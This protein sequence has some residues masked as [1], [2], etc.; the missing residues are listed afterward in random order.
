MPAVL[1]EPAHGARFFNIQRTVSCTPLLSLCCI[2]SA[3]VSLMVARGLQGLCNSPT[4][5]FSLIWG[6]V[7]GMLTARVARGVCWSRVQPPS[8]TG[9]GPSCRGSL[10]V[11][12]WWTRLWCFHI[13]AGG[14]CVSGILGIHTRAVLRMALV[15][16]V[17]RSR[18]CTAAKAAG[19]PVPSRAPTHTGE[20]SA[21]LVREAAGS[22]P[23]PFL[24]LLC[25]YSDLP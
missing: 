24:S 11:P 16:R 2:F 9:A 1:Q 4:W 23:A 13:R 6:P 12:M 8:L 17:G 14:E 25:L 3:S 10:G 19:P 21:P 15:R 22:Q 7:L 18:L 20:P 5:L